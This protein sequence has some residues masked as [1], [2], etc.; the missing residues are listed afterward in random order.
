MVDETVTDKGQPR[1]R[2]AI[3]AKA[4]RPRLSKTRL[5]PK[6]GES[7]A[8]AV[9]AAMI[10]DTVDLCTALASRRPTVEVALCFTPDD[11]E[12]ELRAL[13]P[14]IETFISQR[15]STLG[16][17]LASA[18]EDLFQEITDRVVIIGAD[19]PT[20]PVAI[21]EEAFVRL[22]GG[23]DVV[24]GPSRDGGYYLIGVRQPTSAL[25]VAVPWSTSRVLAA[26]L[27]RAASAGLTVEL[28]PEWYDID[29][30]DDLA[31]L[32]SLV[33]TGYEGAPATRAEI[34]S[35]RQSSEAP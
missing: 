24:I 26:T 33:A 22:E 1:E 17:R 9:A 18:T 12:T 31:H 10:R 34:R 14:G 13:A 30:A 35:W 21:V 28:L 4:P 19:S 6:L 16:Q 8:A 3:M 7:G 23:V 29:D 25:F 2:L 5:I 27:E 32:E 15:G 20:L 11:G